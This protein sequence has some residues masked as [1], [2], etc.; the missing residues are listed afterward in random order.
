MITFAASVNKARERACVSAI[1]ANVEGARISEE[2]CADVSWPTVT[3]RTADDN[4]DATIPRFSV[5]DLSI[6]LS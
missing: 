4:S 2:V 1:P 3:S 6:V 5:E